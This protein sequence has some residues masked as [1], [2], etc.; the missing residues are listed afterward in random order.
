MATILAASFAP[1]RLFQVI[2]PRQQQYPEA[3]IQACRESLWLSWYDYK[4]VLMVSYEASDKGQQQES[5]ERDAPPSKGISNVKGKEVLTGIAE[6]ERVGKGWE[7][8]YGVWGWWDPRK[9]CLSR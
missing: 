9:N 6:W 8:V 5:G 2:F 7:N 3:F 4:K 1:D